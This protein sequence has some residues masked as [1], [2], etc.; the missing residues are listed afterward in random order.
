MLEHPLEKS[1][2]VYC[3]LVRSDIHYLLWKIS[4]IVS[5]LTNETT[6]RLLSILNTLVT[7]TTL[8]LYLLRVFFI[9]RDPT[10]AARTLLYCLAFFPG[11]VPPSNIDDNA[12][13]GRRGEFINFY[14]TIET[15]AL[16]GHA[17]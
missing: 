13:R 17:T 10:R 11:E 5:D 2:D 14:W 7:I 9:E 6:R 4:I 15:F 12:W 16:S 3:N 8:T 1:N